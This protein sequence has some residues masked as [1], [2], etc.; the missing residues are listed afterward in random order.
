MST[1]EFGT[2]CTYFSIT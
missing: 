1:T 2:K